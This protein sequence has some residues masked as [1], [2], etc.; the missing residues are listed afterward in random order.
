MGLALVPEPAIV[1]EQDTM[2]HVQDRKD[3][4]RGGI[5][6]AVALSH[7][8][9]DG[10]RTD[11][12]ALARELG[13][14]FAERAAAHDAND[15]FVTM[16]Y[17]ELKARRVFSAG[18]PAELGGGGASHQELCAMLRTFAHYCSST[19][20]ALS[21]HTHQVAV[22]VWRWRYESAPVEPFLRRVAAEELVLVSTGG[23]DFLAGSG[24]ARKVDGGYRVTARKVFGSGSPAG[25]LLMTMAICDDPKTGPTVLHIPVPL[26]APGVTILDNWHTLGMRGTGSNDIVLDDVFVPDGAVGARRKPG[27]WAPVFHVI[28]KIAMPLIYSVYVGVAENARDLAV[29]EAAKKAKD[30]NVQALAGEMENELATARMALRHMIEA[31]ATSSIGVETTNEVVIGRALAGRSSIRTVEKAMEVVGGASFFRALG[32]ERLFRDVQGARFHP[33]QEK[34]QLLYTGRLALGLDVNG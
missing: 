24:S 16:N 18:V 9:S 11:W 31:A 28:Y 2:A 12:V 14:R 29:R 17:A 6:M 32:L 25:S 21:M 1:H 34:P 8:I 13:P 23:S 10:Q 22:P 19:A 26:D 5:P 7:P 4:T 33:L 27:V 30:P 3:R 15:T 20:L